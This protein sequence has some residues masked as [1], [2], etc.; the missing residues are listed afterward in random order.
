MSRFTPIAAGA[1][2]LLAPVA[3]PAQS[4]LVC[5]QRA[6]SPLSDDFELQGDDSAS[7]GAIVLEAGQVE[8]TMQDDRLRAS[9]S[10]GVRVT[11]GNRV[12]GAERAV[13]DPDELALLLD[14]NVQYR[15]PTTE[16][17]SDSATFSYATGQIVF[18]GA[19]FQLGRGA[20]RGTAARVEISERGTL[21]LD[22]VSYTT[23]P[24]GSNDWLLLAGDIDLDTNTGSGFARDVRLRFQGVPIL[25]TPWLSF[26]LGDARKTGLLTP[27]SAAPAAAATN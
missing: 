4:S 7:G 3:A 1:C 8:A 13:Y 27:R 17:I 15:D 12:A 9:M 10:G 23:C 16:I 14:G 22:D 5:D 11:R 26:P 6:I 21:G 19:E 18:N 20:S 2:L 25:Y 24:P